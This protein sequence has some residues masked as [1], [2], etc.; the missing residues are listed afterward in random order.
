ME[1]VLKQNSKDDKNIIINKKHPITYIYF[2]I[3]DITQIL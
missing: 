1:D 2:K 3:D